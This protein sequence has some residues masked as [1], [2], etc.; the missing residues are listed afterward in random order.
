MYT[1][2]IKKSIK[3][4]NKVELPN[5]IFYPETPNSGI[6]VISANELVGIVAKPKRYQ[7]IIENLRP[8]EHIAY[9]YLVFKIKPQD[10][11]N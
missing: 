10:L 1:S 7:W 5:R 6:V 4:I 9:S 3:E 8:V 11:P 2:E